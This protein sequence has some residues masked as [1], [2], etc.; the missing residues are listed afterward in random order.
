LVWLPPGE[1]Y[2]FFSGA[3]YAGNRWQVC[4]GTL[5][6]VP[7]FAKAGAIVP[8]GPKVGW[9]GVEN[10]AE[11]DVHIFAGANNEFILYEDDGHTI[12]Y[13]D[14]KYC[15]TAFTQEWEADKLVFH[16]S[17]PT[18]Q[19]EVVPGSRAYQLFI[20]GI[21]EPESVQMQI[22]DRETACRFAYN[23]NQQKLVIY[24]VNLASNEDM[25]LKV[26]RPKNLL[27]R[28]DGRLERIKK[29][30]S[31][32]RMETMAKSALYQSLPEIMGDLSRIENFSMAL[33][34]SQYQ[35]L[36]D[37]ILEAGAYQITGAGRDD[38]WLIW[39]NGRDDR[40][41]YLYARENLREW[42]YQARFVHESGT[43]P[44]F[45][46]I[47]LGQNQHLTVKLGKFSISRP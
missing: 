38:T 2:D 1:W 28:H 25:T 3:Y 47:R 34:T 30:V 13:R 17:A 6:R 26:R 40:A 39:N 31:N 37:L 22:N 36:Y 46:I 16:I 23:A 24:T 45:K 42:Y 27:A 9:G 18:G 7:V 5:D 14:G 10:P 4:Y 44:R 8:L 43:I 41:T 12:D 35:C 21:G 19:V 33:R 29:L 15:L 11:F 32:F 20:Y